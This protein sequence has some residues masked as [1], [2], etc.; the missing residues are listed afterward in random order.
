[1]ALLVVEH[2][3]RAINLMTNAG[4]EVRKALQQRP[5]AALQK[6][7]QTTCE[8]L[9]A[10]L[11]MADETPLTETISG[12]SGFAEAFAK[13]G[14]FDAQGRSLRQ[15]DLKQRLF[16]YRCS[17]LIYSEAF[18]ALPNEA[19]DY[20]YRRLWEVLSGKDASRRFAYLKSDERQAIREI[21]LA[22]KKGLPAYWQKQG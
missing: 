7:L 17:Y 20:L 1:M 6:T 16:R 8:P 18:D 21:L 14:P 5:P 13:Q 22:T 2:Q 12:T 19:R 3:A 11:L 9:L 15:L 4:W 10:Y